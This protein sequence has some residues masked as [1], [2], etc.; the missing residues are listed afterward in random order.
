MKTALG[1]ILLVAATVL[2]TFPLLPARAGSGMI[3]GAPHAP[4]LAAVIG[5]VGVLLLLWARRATS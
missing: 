4:A 3:G 1:L 5:V 2:G